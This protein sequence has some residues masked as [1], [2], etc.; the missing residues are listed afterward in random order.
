MLGG[1]AVAAERAPSVKLAG[2]ETGRVV[3]EVG[4]GRYRFR[5]QAPRAR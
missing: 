2:A 4:S 1:A 5:V 3:Y